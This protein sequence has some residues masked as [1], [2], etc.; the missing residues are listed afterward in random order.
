MSELDFLRISVGIIGGLILLLAS[1]FGWWASRITAKLDELMTHR[2]E[3]LASFADA[4]K[5]SEVHHRLW[6]AFEHLR[7]GKRCKIER[8][9]E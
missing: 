2:L 8:F 4:K 6:D 9:E 1:V 7:S 5:N 3:C